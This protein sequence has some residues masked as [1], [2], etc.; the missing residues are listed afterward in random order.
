VNRLFDERGERSDEV[1]RLEHDV[2]G[3][4]A[5]GCLE[6]VFHHL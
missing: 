4:V 5:P 6:V 3:A 1:Q 2:G